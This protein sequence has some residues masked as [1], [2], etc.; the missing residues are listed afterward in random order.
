MPG[1][2]WPVPARKANRTAARLL[3]RKC[4]PTNDISAAI[5]LVAAGLCMGIGAIGPG[6]GEG[7]TAIPDRTAARELL[8]KVLFLRPEK[9]GDMNEL[10]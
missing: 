1:C 10:W 5:A 2:R 3:F 8:A 6:I 4:D 7:M 9:L